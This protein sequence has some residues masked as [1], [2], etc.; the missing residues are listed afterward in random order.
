MSEFLPPAPVLP[1][2]ALID[3]T[4][5]WDLGHAPHLLVCGDTGA[6]KTTLLSKVID[7]AH[8][9]DMVVGICDGKGGGDFR[10][11]GAPVVTGQ[12]EI[13]ATLEKVTG[14]MRQRHQAAFSGEQLKSRLLVVLDEWAAARLLRSE[15]ESRKSAAERV[16][17]MDAALASLATQ[18]RSAG[19]HVVLGIQR[20]DVQLL[21]SGLIRDNFRARVALGHLSED[22]YTMVFPGHRPPS[23]RRLSPGHGFALGLTA[24]LVRPEPVTIDLPAARGRVWPSRR[25]AA[26]NALPTLGAAS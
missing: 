12:S 8:S 16:D 21:G 23:P 7:A 4:A 1:L 20:P 19:M 14:V 25:R 2:G 26:Q 18:G 15:G 22:G 3:Q 10:E 17:A 11:S 9:A 5:A 13:A 24:D 6:G